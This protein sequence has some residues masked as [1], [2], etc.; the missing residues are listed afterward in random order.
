MKINI[1]IFH[2]SSIQT[3]G[4]G[5]SLDPRKK[6]DFNELQQY[7]LA[8]QNKHGDSKKQRYRY[9]PNVEAS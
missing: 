2:S 5:E 4:E 9:T 7:Y 8:I 1:F 6:I 3:D